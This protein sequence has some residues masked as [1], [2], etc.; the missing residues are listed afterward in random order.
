M[1]ELFTFIVGSSVFVLLSFPSLLVSCKQTKTAAQPTSL[2]AT[3]PPKKQTKIDP[4]K[5]ESRVPNAA[6]MN[7]SGKDDYD[8]KSD[9]K[10]PSAM[11]T[12]LDADQ[13]QGAQLNGD[14]NEGKQIVS[15]SFNPGPAM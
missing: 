9:V 14:P 10:N 12:A 5:Y 7:T 8:L 11:N 3:T 4:N 13:K 6:I 2:P 1:D 15:V